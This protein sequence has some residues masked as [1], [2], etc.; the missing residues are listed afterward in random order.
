MKFLKSLS[1]RDLSKEI[2]A[3]RVDL[4]VEDR[5]NLRLSAILPTVRFLQKKKS[6]IVI[7]GHEGRPALLKRGIP[8]RFSLK[9]FVKILAKEIK[10]TVHF[11]DFKF[12]V[13]K[14]TFLKLR[15]RID[16]APAGSVF[17][18][19]NL[20]FLPGELTNDKKLAANLA[21]L[22]TFYVNDAFSASHRANA[23]LAAITKFLPSYG[24]LLLEKEIENLGRV[25]KFNRKPLVVIL[26][27]A[28]IHDK[29]GLIKNL[30]SRAAY[31]LTGGG[32]ANT[33]FV[34][35]G[36]PVGNSIYENMK[37]D[38]SILNAINKKIILPLDVCVANRKIQ[39]IGEETIRKYSY[40]IGKSKAIIWNGPLGLI[41]DKRFRR[42]SES[43]ATAIMKSR[44]EA[45]IGGGETTMLFEKKK[46]RKN[47][48]ISTGGGAMLE[49]L[50]G[51]KLPGIAAL[52]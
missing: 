31:F 8:K 43:V 41:E 27:G 15:G 22:G 50:A 35:E 6:K 11:L 24:G 25:K 37:L 10:Q 33:L 3:L 49:F 18:L 29:I 9:P 13:S 48:F 45:V 47:L 52:K 46:L 1:G 51:K 5:S 14:K 26:G 30:Y 44:A 42:G 36:L 4:N 40:L 2:C 23:S 7:L 39:D 19:E 21:L 32:I 20:R 38:K 28:K 34:A 12:P 17:L 16:N